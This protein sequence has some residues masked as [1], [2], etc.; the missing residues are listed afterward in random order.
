MSFH[1]HDLARRARGGSVLIILLMVVLL[2][3]FF[4][5]QVM[6]HE[7]YALQSEE[8]RLRAVPL[9]A[10][11]GI[12]Y[13]RS[14]K[15]IAENLP[16][17]TVSVLAPTIQALRT[18][19]ERLG[20]VIDL[21][22]ADIR[23][24]ER[25]FR[26]EPNRPTVIFPDASID[27]VAVLEEHR[28][29]FPSLIIQSVPKRY[30]PDG[31]AVSAFVGYTSEISEAEL[32]SARFSRYKMGQVIGK[33]GIERQ[34]EEILHGSEGMQFVEVDARGRIIQ[35]TAAVPGEPPRPAPPL[36][37]N[38]DLDLQNHIASVFA[39]TLIG[40][41]V[42]LDPRTGGVLAL[43]SAPGY[44]PNR[45]TGGIRQDYWTQ[46]NE[47]PKRPLYNKAVQGTYPPGSTW[48]LIDAVIALEA[49]LVD[50]TTRMPVACSGGY[51]YGSRYFRCWYSQGHGSL[52]LT[53]AIA[54]SCNVYFY[55]LG[56]RIGL[57]RMIAGGVELGFNTKSGLDLPN[58]RTPRFPYGVDYY[59]RRYGPRG[60]TQ[61]VVLNLAIGQAENSQTL[62]SMA[63]FYTALA[64]D[65]S[66]AKPMIAR[67]TPEREQ[68]FTLTPGQMEKLR[69]AMLQVVSFQGT[70]GG[71]AVPGLF[72]GGKTGTAQSGPNTPDHAWF[73]GMAPVHD[74]RIV[75]AVMIEF[76]GSGSGAARVASRITAKYLGV[77]HPVDAALA[78]PPA[79][80]A[81]PA[82]TAPSNPPTTAPVALAR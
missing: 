73:V 77:P 16:A 79:P 76:G 60:W 30:Y 72:L 29:D 52:D 69:A 27:L 49:G 22:P 5:A 65:G 18:E 81:T 55:Q 43:Y 26:R 61:S 32:A 39:D 48:K 56:L 6:E 66:A 10:P 82:D 63:K 3:A 71:S 37:T 7:R 2:S 74:P 8:N 62:V 31:E 13:D 47:D 44:D 78:R 80:T 15:V 17:Y 54:K 64:T 38:I 58:E 12:I 25:L 53:N 23:R 59:N 28:I 50:F 57:N 70:A 1:P 46:L 21:T 11:R 67:A 42:A 9:P 41:A 14:G 40:G 45:F 68:L 75:L 24:A 20:T 51:Q 33:D 34:Y 4:K 35:T 19:L 36:H